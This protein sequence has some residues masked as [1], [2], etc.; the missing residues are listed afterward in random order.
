MAGPNLTTHL[1]ITVAQTRTNTTEQTQAYPELSGQTF[2]F[3]AICQLTS[4]GYNQAW[5]GSTYVRGIVGVSLQPAFNLGTS[6]AGAP[7]PFGSVG[8]PGSPTT[9]G[10][11]PNQTAAVNIPAGA[12]FSDGRSNIA[13][14]VPTTVFRGQVDNSAGSV[15]ADWTPTIANVGKEYG[16]TQS[17]ADGTW[18]IDLS[19]TTVGTNTAVTIVA[20]DP[21]YLAAGSTTSSV[22]NGQVYFC[23][24]AAVSQVQN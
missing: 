15:A 20:L 5:D 22:A 13:Q 3:G 12:T 14:A 7:P 19:K 21:E 6:G 18:Y 16:A 8:A 1:P 24:T 10:T 23:F 4:A 9:Y 11:V 17:S 2:P